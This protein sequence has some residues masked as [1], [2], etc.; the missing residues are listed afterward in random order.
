MR[1]RFARFPDGKFKA[2]T[3][4][5]DDGVNQDLR[6]A[7]MLSKYGMKGTFNLNSAMFGNKTKFGYRLSPDEIK[8]GIINK[9]H[10][11]AV[12]GKDHIASACAS[13]IDC[14]KDA[15]YCREELED[16]FDMIIRGMAYPDS[17]IRN[18]A[19]GNDYANV[20][21][22][23]SNLGI[24][25]SRT[26]GGDNKEF[27]LPSDFHAWM[28]TAHHSNPQI[29]EWIDAFN[30]IDE[31]TLYSSRNFPRLFYLW[32]HTYEFDSDNNWDHIE[33]ICEKISGREDVWYATNIEIYDYMKAYDSLVFN[34]KNT[35]VYN[36]S[37]IKVWFNA[38][39]QN[40]AVEPGETLVIK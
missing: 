28:P 3:F 13:P 11:I 20:K 30:D 36:P 21:Q 16:A 10:E 8:E 31:K 26:L 4:S 39:G 2:V 6:F 24:V 22:I 12:H 29:F 38:D 9:G 19:N 27:K 33:K 40:Y 1:Y 18:P 35:K 17:G 15:L 34:V 7:E 25:Y 32:G 5:Y 37:L 14:I 23:L